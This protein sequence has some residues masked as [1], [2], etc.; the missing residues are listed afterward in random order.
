MLKVGILGMG[1]MGWFH[2]SR[3]FQNPNAALVAIADIR[4]ERLEAKNAVSINLPDQGRPVDLASVARYPDASR[5]IAEAEVDV[6]DV[7][8]PSFLHADYT[9]RALEAGRHVLC[10][11]PMALNLADADRM[12]AAAGSAGRQLMIA[13]CVRFWPE[14]RYLRQ[15]TR[16]GTY[17]KLL[18]LSLYRIAGRPI[19]WSWQDWYLDPARSGGALYDLHIH[20]VDFVND[21]LGLPDTL[22]ATACRSGSRQ[23]YD[24][25]HTT[26]QYTYGPQVHLHSGWSTAQIPFKAGYE[27]WFERGFIRLDPGSDPA[28]QVFDD[29]GKINGHPAAYEPG[30]A[31]AS[32]IAYFLGCVEQ[33]VPPVDCLPESARDSLALLKREIA[34]I[35]SG[36]TISGNDIPYLPERKH[37]RTNWRD[38]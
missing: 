4:P 28:L 24:I 22:Q 8:L 34:A 17:G 16:L 14:Y 2:A 1:G 11:K 30:D 6:V 18:S 29:L 19:G 21:L 20:D 10:E 31:Y 27:A 36:Q 23:A 38:Y 3:Y 25:I 7:C 35:E 26:Y 9:I 13:Q 37:E 32:E 33:G 12:I 5:L 15:C